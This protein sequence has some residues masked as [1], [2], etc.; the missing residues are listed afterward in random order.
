MDYRVFA[1]NFWQTQNNEESLSYICAY[2]WMKNWWLHFA[3][4]ALSI[5]LLAVATYQVVAIV[6]TASAGSL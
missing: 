4:D 2:W 5:M 6:L 1:A 3:L